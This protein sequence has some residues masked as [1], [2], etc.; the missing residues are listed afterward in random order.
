MSDIV[1]P[2]PAEGAAGAAKQD[3]TGAASERHCTA[4]ACEGAAG[5]AK[6]GATGAAM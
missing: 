6:Q 5:A 2:K 4:K 1:Q 3:A